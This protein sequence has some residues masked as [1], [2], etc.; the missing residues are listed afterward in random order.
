[1]FLNLNNEF[2]IYYKDY[3]SLKGTHV[4]S[5]DGFLEQIQLCK[6]RKSDV[7]TKCSIICK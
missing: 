4:I 5:L 6:H 3:C 7:L 2:Q 1:M